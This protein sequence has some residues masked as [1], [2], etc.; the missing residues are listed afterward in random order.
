MR[1]TQGDT[2]PAAVVHE[3]TSVREGLI[4]GALA[5]SGVA[6]WFLVVDLLAGVPLD[7]PTRLGQAVASLLGLASVADPVAV[8]GYTALHYGAFAVLGVAAAAVVHLAQRHATVLA[9]VLLVFV[10]GEMGFFAMLGLLSQTT[11]TFALAWF[12]VAVGNLLGWLVLG[13]VLWRRHPEL[14]GGFSA[15]LTGT[16]R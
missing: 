6:I 15:A 9:A 14:G 5:A 1:T 8:L 10:V 13:A 16:T 12:E 2:R 7:T 3:G 4:A 11:V